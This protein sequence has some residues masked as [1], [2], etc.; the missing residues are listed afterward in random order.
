M[1]FIVPSATPVTA[2]SGIAATIAVLLSLDVSVNSFVVFNV[3]LLPIVNAPG[4]LFVPAAIYNGDPKVAVAPDPNERFNNESV[5]V[6]KFI[7][8]AVP[9]NVKLDVDEPLS[10][11]LPLIAPLIVNAPVP[12][13]IKEPVCNESAAIVILV[14]N[15]G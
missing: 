4:V 1:P 8:P 5:L 9:F 2:S 10:I 15:K 3:A 7:V 12:R 11:P 14:V 13:F 6:V